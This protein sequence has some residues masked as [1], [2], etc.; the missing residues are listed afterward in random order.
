M[1]Y[2]IPFS[3]G[4]GILLF[5][6]LNYYLDLK[7]FSSIK[8][9]FHSIIE[10]VGD[11][12]TKKYVERAKKAKIKKQKVNLITKYN[13][14]IEN[15]IYDFNLPLTLEGFNSLMAILFA[16]IVIVTVIFLKSV[17]LSMLVGI[18][19]LVG[20]ITY[21]TMQ[22]RISRSIKIE[23]IM[24]AEDLLCPLAR[25]GVLVA[26]KKVL[27]SE[28]YIS[29]NIRPYFIQFVDNCENHGYSFRRAMEILNKQLGPKFDNFSKKAIVFEYNERKGMADIF[30]DIIDENA[31][32]REIN[33][34]KNRIFKKMNFDFMIKT[35][36]IVAFVAYSMTST[37]LRTFMLESGMGRFVI[38]LSIIVICLSFARCQ[39]LQSDIGNFGGD[40]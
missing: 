13:S 3:I 31:A 15:L 26:I 27:E 1:K 25:E 8:A 23:N 16:I 30:L 37:D 40:K 33:A 11:Y 19:V 7:I 35:A 14:V 34:K 38:T 20:F 39:A 22:S 24:D 6:F 18:S 21:F 32:L 36:M 5:F 9:F 10:N 29:K 17:T 4:V 28:E 2:S 12:N